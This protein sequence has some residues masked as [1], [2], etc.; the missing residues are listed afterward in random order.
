MDATEW[1]WQPHKAAMLSL[2]DSYGVVAEEPFKTAFWIDFLEAWGNGLIDVEDGQVS[3]TDK[4][5]GMLEEFYGAARVALEEHQID[6]V[7]VL[8]HAAHWRI[9]Y[10]LINPGSRHGLL[11]SFY[12]PELDIAYSSIQRED[13]YRILV[14]CVIPISQLALVCAWKEEA[15][16]LVA[17]YRVER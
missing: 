5:R 4:G 17:E 16:R 7:N 11:K 10:W 15:V 8:T 14:A 1:L 3:L 13:D 6:S 12:H 2:I 9:V